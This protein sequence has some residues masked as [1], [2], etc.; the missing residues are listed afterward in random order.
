MGIADLATVLSELYPCRSKWYLLSIQLRVD[1]GS[2]DRFKVQYTDSRDLLREV[3]KTWL[4]TSDNPTWE[5]MAQALKSPI[6]E[7]SRLAMELQQKYCSSG[8][9]DGE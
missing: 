6:I 7:E 3:I 8:P 9:V 1:M 2:L 4:T 5:A